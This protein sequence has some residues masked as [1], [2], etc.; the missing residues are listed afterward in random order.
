MPPAIETIQLGT[1]RS[2]APCHGSRVAL[3]LAAVAMAALWAPGT[4]EAQLRVTPNRV[5]FGKRGHNERPT[6]TITVENGFRVPIHPRLVASCSCIEVRP[7]KL[8]RAIPPGGKET[9]QVSMGS[10]R[11]IGV[12]DKHIDF[13][14][15]NQA[16]ASAS[17]PVRMSVFEEFVI[18]PRDLR[19]DGI[20]GGPPLTQEVRVKRGPRGVGAGPFTLTIDGV[21]DAQDSTRV[22][23]H[24]AA[25]VSDAGDAKTIALTLKST[26]PEGKIW[27]SL[28]AKLDGK[29]LV[30]PVVGEVFRGVKI[31]P[32]YFNFS[33][34]SADDAE[35]LSEES[36]LESTD[37]RKFKIL[38]VE[39][40][41]RDTS[42]RGVKLVCEP[43]GGAVGTEGTEHLLVARVAPIDPPAGAKEPGPPSTDWIPKEGSF[44][45]TV[46]V[47]T[48]HPE[49]SEVKLSFF[50]F[51]APPKKK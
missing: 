48:D 15:G 5:D 13:F 4:V 41:L 34:I 9:F 20:F 23:E 10:G 36:K 7:S 25:K 6:E 46:V 50:G 8:Q 35:S 47:R 2:K 16:Q 42:A 12:L 39:C 24:F 40:S 32:T 21:K 37:G 45:G 43:K 51:F 30:L 1:A 31:V 17:L 28:E 44:N 26:H 14:L 18:E 11:A 38:S 29:L 22:I 33:R 19:F 27:A 3:S 49:K